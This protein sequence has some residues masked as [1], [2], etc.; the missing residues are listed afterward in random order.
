[1]TLTR[2]TDSVRYH[3]LWQ[4]AFEYSWINHINPGDLPSWGGSTASDPLPIS[5]IHLLDR[6]ISQFW[7]SPGSVLIYFI[8]LA[9]KRQSTARPPTPSPAARPS[10]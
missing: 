3:I 7:G 5:M 8:K 1:V 4:M 9:R 6:R 10:F 2:L